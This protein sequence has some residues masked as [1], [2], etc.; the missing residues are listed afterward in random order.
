MRYTLTIVCYSLLVSAFVIAPAAAQAPRP[1][2]RVI[3]KPLRQLSWHEWQRRRA[4]AEHPDSR[5]GANG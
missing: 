3:Y 4:R 1:G 2:P 5:A